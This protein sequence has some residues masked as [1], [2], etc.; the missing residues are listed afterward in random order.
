MNNT[1][2][3]DVVSKIGNLFAKNVDVGYF[4]STMVLVHPSLHV[5]VERLDVGFSA[6]VIYT[7]FRNIPQREVVLLDVILC[8]FTH[9][10]WYMQWFIS[11]FLV[12]FDKHT[13]ECL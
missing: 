10:P 12:F 3:V 1:F 6:F 9:S 5:A 4:L 7:T 11:H 8:G 13:K 2:G